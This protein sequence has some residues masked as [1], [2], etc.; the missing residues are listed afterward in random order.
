MTASCC[1]RDEPLLA[2][3]NR[4]V[5]AS[6]T[7]RRARRSIQHLLKP[8]RFRKLV[9]TKCARLIEA[10][11]SWIA[12][13][14]SLLA[15]TKKRSSNRLLT[16]DGRMDCFVASLLAMTKKPHRNRKLTTE[17]RQLT[18]DP[19]PVPSLDGEG[20]KGRGPAHHVLGHHVSRASCFSFDGVPRGG[21]S[22]HP[23]G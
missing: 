8:H 14:R 13:S 20:I 18:P 2:M 6:P 4:I 3:T 1:G 10:K 22:E 11:A 5:I 19:A 15:M 7:G 21:I 12:S 23:Y 9:R 16:T 17:N